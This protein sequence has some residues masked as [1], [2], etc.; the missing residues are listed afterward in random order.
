MEIW[1]LVSLG[2]VIVLAFVLHALLDTGC[3]WVLVVGDIF[4]LGNLKDDAT[5]V[6]V[7]QWTFWVC[8]ILLVPFII[9]LACIKSRERS[10]Q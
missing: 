5:R 3:E 9:T 10:E 6:L 1:I 4:V 7:C 2:A 8:L